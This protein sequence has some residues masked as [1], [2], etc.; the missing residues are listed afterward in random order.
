MRGEPETSSRRRRLIASACRL[1]GPRRRLGLSNVHG[2]S[3][4]AHARHGGPLSSHWH[5]QQLCPRQWNKAQKASH[6]PTTY[7]HLADTT[8]ITSLT[9]S[10][11]LRMIR[12]RKV[13]LCMWGGYAGGWMKLRRRLLLEMLSSLLD[14][15]ALLLFELGMLIK[16]GSQGSKLSGTLF[17]ST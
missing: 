17:G 9:K 16:L 5:G 14:L 13:L 2:M 10:V 4:A 12:R 3:S 15:M 6:K 8:G 7:L 1:G 11:R